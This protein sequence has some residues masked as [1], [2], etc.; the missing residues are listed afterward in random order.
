MLRRRWNRRFTGRLGGM[1]Y[2]IPAVWAMV[3]SGPNSALAGRFNRSTG[4]RLQDGDLVLIELATCSMVIGA[5]STH[6]CGRVGEPEVAEVL[7]LTT[8][9]RQQPGD[10]WTLRPTEALTESSTRVSRAC[11]AHTQRHSPAWRRISTFCSSASPWLDR[12]Q[13]QLFSRASAA[14]V[15]GAVWERYISRKVPDSSRQDRCYSQCDPGHTH[16]K[17]ER[18]ACRALGH[19]VPGSTRTSQRHPSTDCGART[20]PRK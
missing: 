20:N 17:T 11:V 10:R 15:L 4:R 8:S 18:A 16:F 1:E 6:G 9:M 2:F 13:T 19:I 5:I 7:P 14:I 12:A 3:Q